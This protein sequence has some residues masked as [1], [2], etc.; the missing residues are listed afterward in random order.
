VQNNV[1]EGWVRKKNE[2]HPI[3]R[4]IDELAADVRAQLVAKLPKADSICTT[5]RWI[6][7]CLC[8]LS[9]KM[10]CRRNF[11]SVSSCLD[12]QQVQRFSK[13]STIIPW[14]WYTLAKMCRDV[15]RRCKSH[16]WR[17]ACFI[18]SILLP[19]TWVTNCQTSGLSLGMRYFIHT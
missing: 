12:V 8:G 1:W 16:V 17:T 5:I 9:T 19:K 11:Y 14:T 10:R 3:V 18:G 4:P 2:K 13:W 15:Q 7:R 6:H